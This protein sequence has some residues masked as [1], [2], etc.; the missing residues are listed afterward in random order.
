MKRLFLCVLCFLSLS[1]SRAQEISDTYSN[2]QEEVPSHQKEQ[3]YSDTSDAESK[4][5]LL[6]NVVNNSLTSW[7]NQIA[8]QS[9]V[10]TVF[11]IILTGVGIFGATRINRIER[12]YMRIEKEED[13]RRQKNEIMAYY[14]RRLNELLLKESFDI[15]N[16]NSEASMNSEQDESIKDVYIGYQLIRLSI[17]NVPVG[18]KLSE[19]RK[20]A[21]MEI[22]QA[23]NQIIGR[24]GLDDLKVLQEMAELEINKEKKKMIKKAAKELQDRL[25]KK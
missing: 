15:K 16:A 5:T 9:I 21:V 25:L 11:S 14:I 7:N 13:S 23:L 20:Q 6:V 22:E 10:L 2:H 17:I 1:G 3:K 4:L 8:L 12:R 18:K 19:E 24:G